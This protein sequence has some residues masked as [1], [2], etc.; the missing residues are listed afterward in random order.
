VNLGIRQV[1]TAGLRAF[2]KVVGC[3]L[4]NEL[5][6][7]FPVH[8]FVIQGGRVRE[9][10]VT[11]DGGNFSEVLDEPSTTRIEARLAGLG[12]SLPEGYQGEVNLAMA[13]WA[14]QVSAALERGFVLTIDYGQ[15]AAD[16]YAPA[17]N[18]GTLVCFHQHAVQGDPY[19]HIGQQDITSHVDFTTLTRLGEK[20]GLT[21]EGCIPQREFLMNLGFTSF[22]DALDTQGL[23]AARTAL[24]RMAMTALV[25]PEQYGDL[26]VL[27]QSKGTPTQMKL[28]GF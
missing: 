7:N 21:T 12:L 25:D 19:Q 20:H 6:D 16:L 15:H 9:V 24:S 26:K 23:S 18:R 2:R 27:A 1:K 11:L 3:I 10:Y 5:I 17:N 28:L 14:S 22:L 8:R 4:S 13:D